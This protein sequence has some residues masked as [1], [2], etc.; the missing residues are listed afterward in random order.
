M[1]GWG[2]TFYEENPLR[3]KTKWFLIVYFQYYWKYNQSLVISQLF[4][5]RSGKV[6]SISFY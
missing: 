2:D 4:L 5:P 1:A 3:L 6:S